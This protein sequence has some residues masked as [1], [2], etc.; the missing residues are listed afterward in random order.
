MSPRI[1]G[2]PVCEGKPIIELTEKEFTRL[3]VE[4]AHWLGYMVY[5]TFMS[6]HSR[7]GYPDLTLIKPGRLIF[8]E[9][10]NS[11]G[12]VSPHQ[13]EWLAALRATG[14][15]EVYLWRPDDRESIQATLENPN[16][17]RG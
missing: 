2:R 5:H 4:A 13:E 17:G 11:K 9:L 15:C 14:T 10:K 6:I 12:K 1:S 16:L 3:V 7:P 8:A